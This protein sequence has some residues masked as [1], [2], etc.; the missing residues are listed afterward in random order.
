[1]K[2]TFDCVEMK[3][4]AQEELMAEYEQRKHEFSSIADFINAKSRESEWQRSLWDK[5]EQPQTAKNMAR[6][7]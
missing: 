6:R 2:K 3:R 1:M 5:I 4:R 7:Y